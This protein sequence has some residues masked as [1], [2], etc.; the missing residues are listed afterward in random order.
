MGGKV[1]LHVPGFDRV[2]FPDQLVADREQ[3]RAEEQ[4]EAAEGD[5]AADHAEQD[6]DQGQGNPAVRAAL[7]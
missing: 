2:P 7:R 1:R 5:G 4:A 3:G 6:Q